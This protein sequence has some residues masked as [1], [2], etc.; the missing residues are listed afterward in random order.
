MRPLEKC[1]ILIDYA[2]FHWEKIN[3]T[4][5]LNYVISALI[6]KNISLYS[7]C[8]RIYGGWFYD[9]VITE[10]RTE[11][12]K[13]IANWP[14]I[15][16]VIDNVYRIKYTFA[17]S[18]YVYSDNEFA[19]IK[20]TYIERKEKL[21]NIKF[22]KLENTSKS[23]KKMNCKVKIVNKWLKSGKACTNSDCP[24]IFSDYFVR[25]EQKQVDTHIVVDF[26]H[27]IHKLEDHFVFI[28]SNDIDF[29]PCFQYAIVNGMTDRIGLLYR[30]RLNSYMYDLLTH[31]NILV[32]QIE[33]N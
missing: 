31:A 14:C 25:F 9:E 33:E 3:M 23:C 26:I 12:I 30:G 4:N 21:F 32:I 28:M 10:Q 1:L 22:R 2:N 18:L 27:I 7:I 24:E 13:A 8:I 16:R 15:I 6:K 29:L 20:R 19:Q 11:A 17:D 5:L